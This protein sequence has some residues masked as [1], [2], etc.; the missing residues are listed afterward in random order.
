MFRACIVLLKENI[1]AGMPAAITSGWQVPR[2]AVHGE[3]SKEG[4]F[5][6]TRVYGAWAAV[7]EGGGSTRGW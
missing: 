3:Q 4:H 6:G 2:E 7:R 1:R 5:T